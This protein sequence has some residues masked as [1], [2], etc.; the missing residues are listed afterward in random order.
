MNLLV[1]DSGIGGL[2]VVREIRVLQPGAGIIYLADNAGYP[3]GEKPDAL[4]L[5]HTVGLIGRAIKIFRPDALVI[6][7]NTASTIALAALRVAYNVPFIGCVPPVK[8][9]AA[10]SLS[11]HIGLLA[12]PATIRRP[13]LQNLIETYAVGCTVH[14]LGTPVLADL[15]E[16]KL[17]GREVALGTLADAIAPL[18]AQVG[19]ET[20]DAIA[21]GCTHYT[22]LLP[23]LRDLHP[24]VAFFDPAL[25][26]A[27]QCFAVTRDFEGAA[28]VNR[29]FATAAVKDGEIFA[30]RLG[31]FGFRE[32]E[33]LD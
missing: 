23:E 21:L 2:G 1:F 19:A 32:V 13:Y 16:A 5:P 14:S 30:G 18:F 12:T 28:A 29:Y 33:R 8:P 17:F 11:R 27:R 26:V 25:P 15:A 6:A 22:F 3:Y 7:C 31:E 9:A 20:I 4:L 24:R 10:A